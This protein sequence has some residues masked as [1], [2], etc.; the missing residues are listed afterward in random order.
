MVVLSIKSQ[1]LPS[2]NYILSNYNTCINLGK[3]FE[4]IFMHQKKHTFLFKVIDENNYKIKNF[5]VNF[6][7]HMFI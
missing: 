6:V 1:K 4:S 3:S 7:K 2:F 5:N